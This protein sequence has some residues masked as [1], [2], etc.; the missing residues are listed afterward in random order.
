LNVEAAATPLPSAAA[1][2]GGGA[3]IV[4]PGQSP[5]GEYI[6]A[7]LIKRTF[8]IL[9]N[10]ECV[11]A[12]E[13]RSLTPGEM[14]W[15]HP[16]NSSVQYE[17]DFVP[18]KLA[19]D[20]VLN[21]TA[22]APGGRPTTSCMV[23]LQIAAQRKTLTVTGD[24]EGRYSGGRTP[25][26]T[27]PVPFTAMDLRYERAYG[28]TDVY[29]D[30]KVPYPYPRNPLGRGF[31]VLNTPKSVDTLPLPNVENPQTLLTPEQLCLGEFAQWETRPM[32]AGFGWYPKTWLPRALLAGI[33]PCDRPVEQE[34]RKAYA[35]LVPAG[36]RQA[37]LTHGIGDMDFRF[38]NGASSGC[39]FPYLKGG[40]Q[41]ATENLDRR[42]RVEFRLPGDAPR[43]GLDIG[44][45][46]R[47]PGE[48]MQTVMIRMDERQLDLVWRAAVPYRGPDWLPEMRRMDVLI[49]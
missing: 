49:A 32:P 34:L 27:D 5:E 2:V 36:Q 31:A 16:M 23:S 25:R 15:D 4:L 12:G 33:M 26:F 11:R 35:E 7:V 29:S 48:V 43:I 44:D 47:E 24:R 41:V 30:L 42:G 6:L 18:F 10:G 19:T 22:H 45:G 21:G 20:V 9:A 40:E 39:V 1:N 28:G 37:Y 46:I 38:F 13:D 3:R 14:F 8:D 17:S